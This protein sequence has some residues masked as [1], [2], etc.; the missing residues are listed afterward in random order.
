MID[1]FENSDVEQKLNDVVSIL[2]GTL[3]YASTY[4]NIGNTS[5]KI[6]IIYDEK[7]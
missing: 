7:N 1:K 2:N 5:K 3:Q 6:I 4:D